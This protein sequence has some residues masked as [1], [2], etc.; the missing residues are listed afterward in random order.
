[1]P[2]ARTGI[3]RDRPTWC[4]ACPPDELEGPAR[5]STSVM[6]ATD[7]DDAHGLTQADALVVDD[8]ARAD[9]EESSDRT[10]P[11]QP[12]VETAAA[13]AWRREQARGTTQD[14]RARHDDRQHADRGALTPGAQGARVWAGS[15]LHGLG[16]LVGCDS[17]LRRLTALSTRPGSVS[18]AGVALGRAAPS[19]PATA[20]RAR[21]SSTAQARDLLGAV[22]A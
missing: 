13:G 3:G 4:S 9:D 16:L 19:A 18:I 17:G 14:H 21:S 22:A 20:Q 6:A 1:M 12:R 15:C 7:V 10:S 2:R 5:A 8:D 11:Q